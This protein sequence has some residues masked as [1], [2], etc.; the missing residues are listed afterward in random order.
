MKGD[1]KGNQ[2]V[3]DVESAGYHCGYLERS[4]FEKL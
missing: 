2:S 3:K 4:P 1:R